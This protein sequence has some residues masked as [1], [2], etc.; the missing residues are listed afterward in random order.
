MLVNLNGEIIDS[1]TATVSI[2]DRGLTLGHGLFETGFIDKNQKI[3]LFDYHFQRLCHS[4]KLL[5]INNPFNSTTLKAFLNDLYIANSIKEKCG[6]RLTITD[7]I[8]ERGLLKTT[9]SQSQFFITLFDSIPKSTPLSLKIV[10]TR[11]N[12]INLSSRV[13][14]ISYIDNILAKKEAIASGFDEAL[15]LNQ[16]GLI[17]EGATT[18]IFIVKDNKIYTPAICHGALPGVM[19]AYLIDTL[20]KPAIQIKKITN[21]LLF[22]ADEIFVTNALTGIRAVYKVNEYDFAIGPISQQIAQIL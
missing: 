3:Q 7:G 11:R 2:F 21:Q 8:S 18:N 10:K 14:S 6:F 20:K 5:G 22:S 13:K 9:Q 15:L 1:N 17:S 19:R 4:C 16:Q 12:E